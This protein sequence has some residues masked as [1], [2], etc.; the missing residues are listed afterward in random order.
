[1]FAGELENLCGFGLD[2]TRGSKRTDAYT[3]RY[4]KYVYLSCVQGA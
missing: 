1:L 2:L 4:I 3:S